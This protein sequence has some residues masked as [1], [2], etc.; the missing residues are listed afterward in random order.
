VVQWL[1]KNLDWYL[2]MA[3][4][5]RRKN[6]RIPY[7][8]SVQFMSENHDIQGKMVD[9][10]RTGMKL[11]ADIPE[12]TPTAKAIK[13]VLPKSDKPLQIPCKLVRLERGKFGEEGQTLGIEF[14]YEDE[15]QRL[16]IESFIKEK[17]MAQLKAQAKNAEMRQIPRTD[18]RITEI[19]CDSRGVRVL[20]IDNI[21]IDGMLISFRGKGLR[22][23][24]DITLTFLLP[25]DE[26]ILT[27]SGTVTHIKEYVLKD[28]SKAGI[29]FN[30]ISEL[31]RIRIKNFISSYTVAVAIKALHDKFSETKI[32]ERYTIHDQSKIDSLISVLA[33]E[34][35]HMNVLFENNHK[36]LEL[37][38]IDYGSNKK[39]F[40]IDR[41]AYPANLN[42]KK[43]HIAYFS[44]NL[45]TGT[46][47]FK[48]NL[49]EILEKHAVFTL[50]EVI[51]QA[52]KRSDQREM[53]GENIIFTVVLD[54]QLK[55][56]LQGV[57]LNISKHGFM[58][59]LSV[60]EENRDFFQPGR[61]VNY[62]ANTELGLGTYGEIRHILENTTQEGKKTL[63]LGIESGIKHT[64]FQFRCYSEEDWGK[65]NLHREE[66]PPSARKRIDSLSVNYPNKRGQKIVALVNLTH[67][68]VK[69]PVVILPPAFGKKKETLS[70]L[71]STLVTNARCFDKEIVTIR[72]DGI[73]R[74]GESYNEEMLPKRGY[75][76]LYYRI[77]QG[78]DDL[79]ATIDYVHNNSLFKP[80][81]V[82]VI[83][84]SMSALDV[85]KF[86]S[87]S[88]DHKIDIIINIMGVSCGQSAFRNMTGGL[89]IIGNYKLGIQNGQFGIL[90][91]MLDLDNLAEDL[92]EKRYASMTD[93]RLDMSRISIP[94]LWIYGKYDKWIDE[95][96]VKELMRIESHG[97]REVIEI[98]TGHNI[99]SSEDAIKTFKLLAS[100]IHEKLY[101]EKVTPKEPDR[102]SLVNLIA[103]ERERIT[104][105]E[106]FN[107]EEYWKEYLMGKS[108]NGFGYDFYKN[109]KEFKDFL[110]LQSKLIDIKDSEKI[111][112]VGCG[113]GLLVEN[114][115]KLAIDQRKDI[116]NAELI[117]I[118]LIDEALDKTK[119]KVKKIQKYQGTVLPKRM[120][121]MVRDLEPNRLNPVHK[122]ISNTDLD[123]NFLRNR[124][125][126]LSNAA[127][128]RLINKSSK[129]LYEIMRGTSITRS[130]EVY[131]RSEFKGEDC[132][133]IREFNRAARFLRREL[134]E[135]DFVRSELRGRAASDSLQY[136]QLRTSDLEF[137]RLNF[138]DNGLRLHLDFK[139]NQFDKI[140][141]SLFISYVFNPDA[142]FPDFY[143]MLKPNGLLL[144]SSMKPDSDISLIFT[145]Y[146]DKVQHF[147]F[148][149][150]NIK[151]QDISL[152]GAREMLNEAAALFELEED[153]YFKF[154]SDKEL[155]HMFQTAGFSQI[156]VYSSLGDP[157]QAFIVTGR[158]I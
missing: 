157:P 151:G 126:G 83:A 150:T 13:F 30:D 60:D 137:S 88:D 101:N 154:F 147:D 17:K 100:W 114:M 6:T 25:D 55:R 46:Y 70:P 39:T 45:D 42:V 65:L 104:S 15:A 11:V 107:I 27:V 28:T 61:V 145:N 14:S 86:V 94:V 158:K 139:K 35:I 135:E 109:I 51:Y 1:R 115:L 113:I 116:R 5:E 149:E 119:T 106:E 84:F 133:T 108:E 24:D 153:G 64:P 90:G 118:D 72:Y 144:V 16:L 93:A 87:E 2:D 78:Q 31:D 77:S 81:R 125:E 52:E 146:V 68:Q 62:T 124:I 73:N 53:T 122:F 10:S 127:V 129:R 26:R 47:Y 18:C 79:R 155:V 71:A 37:P 59:E 54:G 34:K 40:V 67:K 50:P 4:I 99:R 105:S 95:N 136:D 134:K 131:I 22:S 9:I 132:Q 120:T 19:S 96:E 20:S 36:M 63:Q 23:H 69:A 97:L 82:I 43:D 74:P 56:S 121:Y 103:H 3:M 140:I 138:G 48:T 7:E 33:R 142:L 152:M 49:E 66:L 89:D 44:F 29:V 102:E 12:S 148:S 128:G 111:V 98:P 58:C 80:S 8:T 112:D 75:E 143:R 156:Q 117:M 92:I 91:H 85:R 57:V 41:Q 38:A 141:A 123:F 76:M 110:T 130:D 32:D 21:S